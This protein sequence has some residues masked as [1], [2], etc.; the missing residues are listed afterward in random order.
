MARSDARLWINTAAVDVDGTLSLRAAA[1]TPHLV[2]SWAFD[3]A[4]LREYEIVAEIDLSAAPSGASVHLRAAD[5]VDLDCSPDGFVGNLFDVLAEDVAYAP[6]GVVTLSTRFRAMRSITY[7]GVAVGQQRVAVSRDVQVNP[8]PSGSGVDVLSIWVREVVEDAPVGTTALRDRVNHNGVTFVFN[9]EARVGRYAADGAFWV[10]NDDPAG[11]PVEVIDILPR[12]ARIHAI[13]GDMRWGH[14]AMLDHGS[15]SPGSDNSSGARWQGWHE[16]DGTGAGGFPYEHAFNADPAATGAPI[17]FDAARPEGSIT[18]AVSML[19]QGGSAGRTA[20]DR[21]AI[22]TVVA[23]QPAADAFRPGTAAASKASPARLSDLEMSRIPALVSPAGHEP[24]VD[25][26]LWRALQHQNFHAVNAPNH[27]VVM[28]KATGGAYGREIVVAWSKLFLA[29]ISDRPTAAQKAALAAAMTQHGIDIHARNTCRTIPYQERY[30]VGGGNNNIRKPF[31]A[32]AAALLQDGAM[33]SHLNVD[34]GTGFRYESD[35]YIQRVTQTLIDA[36]FTDSGDRAAWEY[37]P[38]TLGMPEFQ[39]L[40]SAINHGAPWD[41][42]PVEGTSYAAQTRGAGNAFSSVYRSITQSCAYGIMLAMHRIEGARAAWGY[43]TNFAYYDRGFYANQLVTSGTAS[44]GP[45]F[46]HLDDPQLAWWIAHRIQPGEI[47]AAG[48]LGLIE[49]RTVDAVDHPNYATDNTTRMVWQ[50]PRVRA[51]TTSLPYRF[52]VAREEFFVGALDNAAV[53]SFSVSPAL[54]DGLTLT[55]DGKIEGTPTTPTGATLLEGW[56]RWTVTAALGARSVSADVVLAVLGDPVASA[57]AA[58]TVA[59]EPAGG[60]M[61][62][63]GS[64]VS[65]SQTAAP[66]DA[67][68]AIV[69]SQRRFLT[70]STNRVALQWTPNGGAAEPMTT[71]VEAETPETG[72]H[73]TSEIALIVAPT[74]GPGVI[75]A[76]FDEPQNQALLTTLALRNLRVGQV[77]KTAVSVITSGATSNSVTLTTIQPGSLTVVG[78]AIRRGD[79]ADVKPPAGLSLLSDTRTGSSPTSDVT[80]LVFV[81]NLPTGQH[82]LTASWSPARESTMLAAEILAR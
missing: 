52:D 21:F 8:L 65:A 5:N 45:I 4:P 67:L 22:L 69:A 20:L 44:P 70:K 33:L 50:I 2:A 59:G 49:D 19:Q 78:L 10:L 77:G 62:A 71:L 11:A 26:A 9:R 37:E 23:T 43:E 16:L 1:L 48:R 60:F 35:W 46:D 25:W 30:V 74:A 66:G 32:L 53:D 14:G 58:A 68:L 81:G 3:T 18:K 15:G 29:L 76:S 42:T 38:W 55:P 39:N 61:R 64:E 12:S 24:D 27:D 73:S 79:A 47:V 41:A 51:A 54:P 75:R 36:P 63:L 13:Q 17:R 40:P 57:M 28:A 7:L 56:G 31:V 80:L 34:G 6:N 72:H 82:T